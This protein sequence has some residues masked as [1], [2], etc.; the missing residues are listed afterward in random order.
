[1][2]HRSRLSLLTAGAALAAALTVIP[3]PTPAGAETTYQVQAGDT[4]SGIAAEYRISTVELAEANDIIDYHLIRVGQLLQVPVAAPA[5]HVVAPGESVSVIAATYGVT[6]AEI[7]ALN[8]LADPHRIRVGQELLVPASGATELA[9]EAILARYPELPRSIR[10]NPDRLALVPSF[11][12]W[13][14]HYAVPPDL[15][16]AVA[17]HESGWQSSVVSSAGAIGVGQLL[18]GTAAWLAS[19]I[20]GVA[21]LDAYDPDDNIRMSVRFLRWL[22][23]RFEDEDRALAAYYQGPTSLSLRG[24][25]ES[26]RSYVAVVQGARWRFVPG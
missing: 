13:A 25:Y 26:T 9:P 20:I 21:D 23:V 14:A 5:T 16:M 4:L 15:A 7:V 17:Y 22:L 1:M 10:V 3:A 18:P 12:R 8:G 11:E 6:Q 19:D 2:A 24:P